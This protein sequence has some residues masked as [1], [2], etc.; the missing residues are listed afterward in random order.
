MKKIKNYKVK[1]SSYI[2]SGKGKLFDRIE[3]I[4]TKCKEGFSMFRSINIEED[5]ETEIEYKYCPH[6]ANKLEVEDE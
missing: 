5:V 4:C 6:C 2:Y 1:S 3:V